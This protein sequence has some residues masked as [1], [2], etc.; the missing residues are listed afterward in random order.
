MRKDKKQIIF[1]LDDD[2]DV[3]VI[4]EKLIKD[5]LPEVDIYTFTTYDKFKNHKLL[6]EVSLFIYDILLNQSITG[7]EAAI[8]V[9]KIN[10][11]PVLFISGLNYGFD[12]F[13]DSGL[14][15]DFITKPLVPK[16]LINRIELL[17]KFSS[18]YECFEYEKNKFSISIKELMDHSNIYM[19]IINHDLIVTLCSLKLV[20]DLGYEDINEVEGKSWLNFIK[21]D[22]KNEIS[23]IHNHI[24][25][26]D[27]NDCSKY[28]EVNSR[29]LTKDGS[30]IKVKWF[31]T[32][33][34][35]NR[36]FTFSIG[37]PYDRTVSEDDSLDDIRSYWR[38]IID[39]NNTV[40]KAMKDL[41][42]KTN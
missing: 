22:F 33:L 39:E 35:N 38:H 12:S 40:L 17:L 18:Y 13:R 37:I 3:C 24:S 26:N 8:E 27:K 29:I 30:E 6:P 21:E 41:I 34:N 11:S 20:K 42:K 14:T 36:N 1:L 4:C 23:D 25:T 28:R 2:E 31:N 7:D 5:F 19:V 16:K 32:K 9:N 15:Y 10:K